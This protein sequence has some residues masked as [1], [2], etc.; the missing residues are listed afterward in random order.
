M[1]PASPDPAGSVCDCA[2]ALT[3]LATTSLEE[4]IGEV[5]TRRLRE[6]DGRRR[7]A[8]ETPSGRQRP[9]R[10]CAARLT[11]PR[12]S[13]PPY[14]MRSTRHSPPTSTCG[15][16]PR[17]MS[18]AALSSAQTGRRWRGASRILASLK[19]GVTDLLK[20]KDKPDTKVEPAS[21]AEVSTGQ[22]RSL[23]PTRRLK[24]EPGLT[25]VQSQR[26][27]P[28]RN[29]KGEL[30]NAAPEGL[31]QVLDRAFAGISEVRKLSRRN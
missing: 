13:A 19:Q 25:P 5:F 28:T 9:R 16:R 23:K 24:R 4:R 15:S 18:S 21:K 8:S 27:G 20:E 26:R 6:M 29:R 2:K 12:T 1:R 31:Q 10:S 22:R 7:R 30:M 17:R 11:C 14:R 3:D